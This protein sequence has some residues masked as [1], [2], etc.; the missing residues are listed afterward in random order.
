MR[1]LKFGNKVFNLNK[2]VEAIVPTNDCYE[3]HFNFVDYTTLHVKYKGKEEELYKLEMIYN[4]IF[5][6]KFDVVLSSEDWEEIL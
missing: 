2:L 4:D 5:N 6:S 3:Y 1:I